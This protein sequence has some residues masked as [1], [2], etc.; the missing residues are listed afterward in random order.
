MVRSENS[1][2]PLVATGILDA[3]IVAVVQ[4]TWLAI[5]TVA[6]LT[7]WSLLF[8]ILSV[9]ILLSVWVF[10]KGGWQQGSALALTFVAA[11]VL[12]R[13][14]RP[15]SFRAWITGR[16]WKRR[17]RFHYLRRWPSVCAL[18]GLTAGLDG[19][20]LVP[21]LGKVE[22]G[23]DRD[24][25]TVNILIGQT[26]SDWSSRSES[27]AYAFGAMAVHI[28]PIA[29]GWIVITVQHSDVLATPLITPAPTE[30]TDLRHVRV[31]LRDDGLSWNLGIQ[32]H[33]MLV[34]GATGAGKGSVVWSVICGL[35]PAIRDG[36]VAL[37][38]VDPKGG[39]EFAAG[40]A[41]FTRFSHDTGENTL[42]L[43]RDA[44]SIL[45]ARANRLRGV[46]RQHVPTVEE[47]LIVIVIDE[48]AT[49]TEYLTDRK[50]KA[51]IEQL[52]GLIL[53]QGRAVGVTVIACVQDPS[54]Q[55]LSLRQ[56][57][58]IRIGL[59]LTEGIQVGMVLGTGA[60]ERGALCDLISD[61]TPGVGY[62]SEDGKA[63]ISRV[64]AFHVT[65]TDIAILAATYRA[66]EPHTDEGSA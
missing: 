45:V 46:T 18:H 52:L 24:K 66:P 21:V 1:Q 38:V 47:P 50:L 57:F 10:T 30:P 6:R 7:W 16:M 17:R 42:A 32:G 56:L 58:P 2:P 63:R 40:E 53:S 23:Y 29:P 14:F 4:L 35:A 39:M 33:H 19:T 54:K 59:R 22:V 43:L 26:F 65:D 48:L 15:L 12:W 9:P 28:E 51:E 34:A 31:G 44:C 64:R 27:L 3:L 13:I 49:L 62:V 60:R 8:P 5:R 20:V 11:L 25:L 61:Q 37:W 41:L 55:V 36:L